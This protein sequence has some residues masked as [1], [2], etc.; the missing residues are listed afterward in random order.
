MTGSCKCHGT[1]YVV[2][3]NVNETSNF[4]SSVTHETY[5]IN[6][7]SDCNSNCLIYLLTCKQCSKQYVG[8]TKDN[9]WF[10]WNNFKDNSRKYQCSDTCFQENLFRHFSSPSLNWFLKYVLMTF[11]D[12]TDPSD[13][14]KQ[15]DYWTKTLKTMALFGHN[16]EDSV[17]SIIMVIKDSVIVN[18]Y[19]AFRSRCCFG[20]LWGL[21]F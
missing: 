3:L 18:I 11:I 6:H 20:L 21:W 4:T 16:I 5:K 12:K 19:L 7:K 2:C 8:Q 1:H 15:E 10:Q 9:F 13:P 14:F 17:W